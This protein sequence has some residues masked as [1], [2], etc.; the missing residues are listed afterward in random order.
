MKN[1]IFI[2][3]VLLLAVTAAA[4]E[5]EK[6]FSTAEQQL[7]GLAEMN[8]LAP[9]DDAYLQQL[10]HYKK[11][12]LSVNTA[13]ADEMA[14]LNVL[15]GLQ[16]QQLI[17]YRKLLGKLVN[18]YELQAVP[19]WDVVTIKKILPYITVADEQS[20]AEKLND[21][22]VG[23][24]KTLLLRYGRQ[25]EK[26]KGYDKPAAPGAAYY[27]GSPDRIFFRYSYNYK[28]LLQWGLLGDKDAGEQFFRGYQKAGCDFYSF[29]FF[30]RQLGIV[31]ALALGDFTVNFGQGLLQWQGLAFKKNADV[32]GIKRQSPALMPYRSA[33]EYNFHRGIGITLQKRNWQA[34]LF[35]SYRKISATLHPDSVTDAGIASS[36]LS[37]GYH[38]TAAENSSKNNLQQIAG[39]ANL[40]YR[41]A[42]WHAGISAVGYHFSAAFLKSNN[43]YN[44][45]ALQ[46]SSLINTSIDYSY[47]WRNLHFFG[48][49][50]A[51]N[52]FSKAFINGMLISLDA[53]TAISLLYRKIDRNYQ[54]VNA[55]AFTE[56]V[57][58]VNES[59]FY[60]GIS[61]K[62]FNAWR[63]DAYADIFVF[64]WLKYGV[65]APSAGK[66]FF[67]QA[68]YSP[69][70][71]LEVYARFKNETKTANTTG[72]VSATTV[73]EALPKKDC[74]LQTTIV[75]SNRLTVRNRVELL[76]YGKT[77]RGF[78]GYA[79][80]FYTPAKKWNAGMRLQY[81]ETSSYNERIYSYEAG[82]PHQFSIPFYYGRGVRYYLNYSRTA[83]KLAAANKKS[84]AVMDLGFR[85]ARTIYPGKQSVG[86]GL[87]E[88][89]GSTRSE[90]TLQ[91]VIN[92]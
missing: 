34:T 11:H 72:S 5:N 9:Q 66:D 22:W 78:L 46:G 68:T 76:W 87:D 12:P 35:A 7:E 29:H 32:L 15:S 30:V 31:K 86:A 54:S 40:Q 50:A 36:F 49:A 91:L 77:G 52:G 75:I 43:P 73:F 28:S 33:G 21:R 26:A 56:T 41:G 37:S 27:M 61:I 67:V 81:F 84:H 79:E 18:K 13:T 48:E 16:V 58:P 39:G 14:L 6:I 65:D 69:S 25:L 62:P 57:L 53:K 19:G 92:N 89:A 59:G 10:D 71:Y 2:L 47:T 82:L 8:P 60:A 42:G 64:P 83:I 45:F 24:D 1:I 17:A 51:G 63:L 80:A 4:Q 90:W 88:T 20:I 38:R 74:R 23:G 55:N 85:W 70:K 44:L 3:L